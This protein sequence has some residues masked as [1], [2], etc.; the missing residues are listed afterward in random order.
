MHTPQ[1][2][3]QSLSPITPSKNNSGMNEGKPTTSFN[4]MLNKEVS[5][6]NK[7]AVKN[8]TNDANKNKV[9]KPSEAPPPAKQ[10]ASDVQVAESSGKKISEES[11][12]ATENTDDMS[13]ET[14]NILAFVDQL[15]QLGLKNPA[16]NES[17]APLL[18]SDSANLEAQS[19]RVSSDSILGRDAASKNLMQKVG[20]AKVVQEDTLDTTSQQTASQ[21]KA[22]MSES[23]QLNQDQNKLAPSQLAT[24]DFESKSITSSDSKRA[25]DLN[26]NSRDLSLEQVQAGASIL[27]QQMAK[28]EAGSSE[29]LSASKNTDTSDALSEI[30]IKDVKTKVDRDGDQVEN[31]KMARDTQALASNQD[32]FSSKLELQR[33]KS[34]DSKNNQTSNS[35][36][37]DQT[38]AIG[39]VQ[40]QTP[41]SE[42]TKLNELIKTQAGMEQISPRVGSKA[43][44]QAI[45]QK[46]VWMVAGGE[47]S[48]ELTLNPPD[49]G[50][51][52]V[53]LSISDNQ[54][55]ASFVSSHLDVRE[56]I[57][58]AAPQLR[59]MLDNA[60][61]SL[62]GFSVNAE[63][64]SNDTQFAQDRPNQRQSSSSAR[65]NSETK[66]GELPI[67]NRASRT[68]LGAVDTFV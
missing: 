39:S 13:T 49:L 43:W 45:G 14:N 47:Q 17:N 48:A 18:E 34:F 9:N 29:K 64:K 20:D 27:A 33:D 23:E 31:K 15:S 66:V 30:S 5:N 54:V 2:I 24:A 41:P 8:S 37:A 44:D 57:E 7:L 28:A 1:I 22:L 40:N 25:S 11:E 46:V 36:A 67:S 26:D 3:T 55:D 62:T 68:Q 35:Q 12:S 10:D 56:A 63:T 60:G 6:Q 32:K 21:F 65:N 19:L 59:E 38:N 50:P 16:T 42:T 51:L 52:Q 53:V 58:A 61:I 4:S